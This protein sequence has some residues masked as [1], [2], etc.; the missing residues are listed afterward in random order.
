MA[1]LPLIAVAIYKK[2]DARRHRRQAEWITLAE[3]EWIS[4]PENTWISMGRKFT[5]RDPPLRCVARF[6]ARPTPVG[7][8]SA[9]DWWLVGH[10]RADTGV[11][12][13][14]AWPGLSRGRPR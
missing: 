14:A 7:W 8:A 5:H 9:P 10:G 6:V 12:P 11:R 13:Y 2:P 1:W 3:N 4:L